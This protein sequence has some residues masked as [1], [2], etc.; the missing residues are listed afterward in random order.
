MYNSPY[1]NVYNPQA[2]V[3]KINEQINNL[4]KLRNQIQQPP[5]QQPTNLT[6]NFQLAPTNR[7][8]IRYAE[9]M[10]EVQRDM[11][12]GD[13]P[14]FSKDMSVVWIKNT[15]GEIKT[16][17]LNEIVPKDEKDIKIEFLMSQIEDLKK[18]MK[19]N[20]HN[21]YVDKSNKNEES[22][23]VQAISKSTKKQSTGSIE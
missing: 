19:N 22:T 9:S 18:E 12:I 17:E 4:E 14:Y 21:E 10:S 20:E 15:K 16:Y 5:I 2:N 13:T 6:Q 23:N 1:F 3:D 11:V 8:V 7:D